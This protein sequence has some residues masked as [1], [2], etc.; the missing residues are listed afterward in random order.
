[1][2]LFK[3]ELKDVEEEENTVEWDPNAYFREKYILYV[4]NSTQ[5][6]ALL[7]V[8]DKEL[9][10]ISEEKGNRKSLPQTIMV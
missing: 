2:P 3:N 7:I 10:E 1:V 6:V 9:E 4:N 8:W 5:C